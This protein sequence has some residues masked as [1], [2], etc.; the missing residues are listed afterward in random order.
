MA[1]KW[2]LNMNC[3]DQK[4]LLLEQKLTVDNITRLTDRA[5]WTDPTDLSEF[6][7]NCI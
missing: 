4:K 5:D 1:T 6:T 3:I 7:P 2:V